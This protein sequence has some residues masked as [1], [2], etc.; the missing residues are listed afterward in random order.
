MPE[1]ENEFLLFDACGR[2]FCASHGDLDSVRNSPRL[3]TT[4]FQKKFGRNIDHILLADK[5][6]RERFEELGVGATI[7]GSLC[8]TDDY[9]NDK[10]LYST[11]EQLM[12]IV[13][14]EDG[15]D[16]TYHLKCG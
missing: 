6:H 14:S 10:R 5:H 3:L 7:V 11:P 16:A 15:V 2:G 1:S 12:L 8:G 9:A 4:L 13:N